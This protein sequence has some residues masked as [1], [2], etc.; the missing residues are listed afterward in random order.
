MATPRRNY[1]DCRVLGR[2]RAMVTLSINGTV[3]C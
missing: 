3:L 2:H 1:R